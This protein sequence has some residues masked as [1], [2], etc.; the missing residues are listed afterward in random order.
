MRP[1]HLPSNMPSSESL[2]S[3]WTYWA[4]FY[5]GWRIWIAN[6]MPLMDCDEVYNYWEPLHF[7][8][9]Q[10]GFQTWEYANNYALRTYAYLTP[11]L[12]VSKIFQ[13]VIP[14]IPEPWWP[15]LTNHL[16][17]TTS[18]Q[19]L[20]LDGQSKVALFVLLRSFL[21]GLMAFAEVSFCK[22][23]SIYNDV[24]YQ[25]SYIIS[26][27]AV[28]LV[29]ANLLLTSAGMAH[30]SGALL[31]SSTLTFLW[32][33]AAAA[34]LRGKHIRFIIVAIIAT[35]GIGWPFGV[36]MFVP[37]GLAVLVRERK[38]LLSLGFKIL[39]ITI[40]IQATVMYID[41]QQYEEWVSPT[42]NI[43]IY[44]TKAGG[45]ELYGIEPWTY[46]V[47]N[48]L[49]NFNYVAIVGIVCALPIT[50]LTKGS[51]I[52]LVLL[53]PM[54][55]W[56]LVVGPRPHK[57]ERFLFTIY[58]CICLGAAVS[59][60]ITT[61]L[62]YKKIKKR[63]PTPSTLLFIQAIIW[64]PASVL[65]LSRAFAL[66]KYYT[67][68]LYV[69]SQ[70]QN[71]HNV[72]D[73]TICTCGEWYRFPSSFYLPTT[74]DSFGFVQSSFEGQLPQPFTPH[75]SGPNS[76]NKF[77]DKNLP[78]AHS[79]TSIDDCDYLIDLWTS[80]C[81]ENDSIW[82]PI[83][84]GSFLDAERTATLHRT[85]YV[86]F[87]HENAVMSGGVEYIDYVLYKKETEIAT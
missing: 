39:C 27:R 19:N 41:Y 57:E 70:L 26:P 40:S 75:G 58:P 83:A 6:R 44:N 16:V 43:F 10:N 69:Y 8:L 25:K 3:L 34:F 79:Y 15:L 21:A 13:I 20:H 64:T 36:L 5:V 22:A 42:W 54:Y 62:V 59:T 30:A 85:L 67:T 2:S 46:Y 32:L 74:I 53:S 51:N 65:S 63:I 1:W 14:Y 72:V 48:L 24:H 45:D 52:F 33:I 73:S 86:P 28:S 7:L 78:E 56:L 61:N 12:G 38:H 47:K 82:H 29:T 55:L 60:V 80:D 17:V 4:P 71:E 35:L 31:P 77:N 87:L 68:P 81:R 49:L 66:S 76:I 18:V 9:Y 23:I 37:L 11:L 84:Q 50:L